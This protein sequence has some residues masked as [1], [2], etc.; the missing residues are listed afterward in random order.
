VIN[1]SDTLALA[2]GDYCRLRSQ[3]CNATCGHDPTCSLPESLNCSPR[4]GDW[5][6]ATDAQYRKTQF[7]P[8]HMGG[9]NIGFADGHAKWMMSEAI[10]FDGVNSGG[11]GQGPKEIENL[12]CCFQAAKTY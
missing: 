10:L 7:P 11:Y 5:K 4:Y 8:R 2:Y 6:V 12:S 3:G 1:F 9:A